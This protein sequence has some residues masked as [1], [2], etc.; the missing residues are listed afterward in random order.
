MG[1]L[2]LLMLL[3]ST[4]V[5]NS[6]TISGTVYESTGTAPITGYTLIALARSWSGCNTASSPNAQ[7]DINTGKYTISNLAAG[8]YYIQIYVQS[9]NDYVSEYWA[10]PQSVTDCAAAEPLTISLSDD[11][12][13]KDFQLDGPANISGTVYDEFGDP[14]IGATDLHV[15]VLSGDACGTTNYM[16]TADVNPADG[17]YIAEG[18]A[19]G[20]YFLTT[21]TDED[22]YLKEWWASP[23]SS[24]SCLDAQTFTVASNEVIVEK[25]FHLDVGKI[26]RGTNFRG[27]GTTP[28]SGVSVTAFSEPCPATNSNPIKSYFATLADGT[29]ELLGIGP[30]T[31]YIRAS[32]YV[33]NDWPKE[34]WTPTN[35]TLQCSAAEP[36]VINESDTIFEGINFQISSTPTP[37][38]DIN[39][40]GELNLADPIAALQVAAGNYDTQAWKEGDV[41]GNSRIDTRDA[42]SVMNTIK[43]RATYY[44]VYGAAAGDYDLTIEGHDL[45]GNSISGHSFSVTGYDRFIIYVPASTDLMYFD[46]I[47]L[48]DQWVDSGPDPE[49][50]HHSINMYPTTGNWSDDSFIESLPDGRAITNSE[51]I[52][53]FYGFST[54]GANT[55]TVYLTE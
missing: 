43:V 15:Q 44:E 8:T 52:D 19:A 35:S 25:N 50:T 30:G 32:G 29:F 12:T 23:S 11:I 22:N 18:V 5:A 48:D 9:S 20:N 17:T 4:S 34:W 55:M 16:A 53:S 7:V 41:D 46:A 1:R 21:Y 33:N 54:L 45:L 36:F 38:G 24:T 6:A 26:I 28:L 37:D 42:I 13:D 27:D 39:Q 51:G 3:F 40:D 31:Y 49:L 10:D 14:I 2:L 47:G